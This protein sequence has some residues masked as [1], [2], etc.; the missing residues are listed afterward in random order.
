MLRFAPYILKSLWRHRARTLLTVTGSAAA[1][2]VFAFVEA[3]RDGLNE[4][5]RGAAAERT[6]I[7]YQ[8]NRFC[9][10]TSR[11][12]EDYA[13]RIKKV[14]GVREVVP[15]QVH[16]NN[17]RASLDLVVFHGLDSDKLHEVRRPRLVSGSLSAFDARSD[18]AL[19]GRA[20]AR[21]RNLAPGDQ[22]AIGGISVTI[23]GIFTA[24][25]P[26]EENV[27]YTH[28][29]YL[30]QASGKGRGAVTQFEVLLKEDAN[31]D[32]VA[33]AIDAEF[34]TDRVVTD[35]R[36]RGAFQ[37][38]VIADLAELIGWSAWLGYACVGLVLALVTT[39]TLMAVQDRVREHA[40]LQAIG[41]TGW[42]VFRLVLAEGMVLGLA[43]GAIGIGAALAVLSWSG[44]A[45]GTEGVTL[46]LS[47]SPALALRGLLVS[48][49]VG[50]VAGALP[51][52]YAA[53]AEIVPAL[54]QG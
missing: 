53:S 18:A 11:L 27:L 26:A 45:I 20:L 31:P 17:C 48:A 3:A 13:S 5:T 34:R 35:T 9:P 10:F 44:L 47:A 28:L 2:F 16:I 21:R 32:S 30:Q 22:F 51:G 14:G 8:A 1:L 43:G 42:R 36:P 37:S 50:L 41:F 12:P 38:S 46:A 54:R 39:T 6:L 33:R 23:A 40:L 4:L 25:T 24:D 29:L 7:V 52:W 49:G 15:T 19:A